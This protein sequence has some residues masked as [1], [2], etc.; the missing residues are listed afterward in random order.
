[1]IDSAQK[2]TRLSQ[3]FCACF[4]PVATV[5]TVISKSDEHNLHLR[6]R[7]IETALMKGLGPVIARFPMQELAIR[8]HYASDPDFREACEDYAIANCSLE[9]WQA[10]E[11]KSAHFKA[12]I[13]EL[14][15]EITA[16]LE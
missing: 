16:C 11:A 15:R 1:L 7:N 10:D 3:L 4:V 6:A 14:E 8:R 2:R 9:R 5:A 12:M 13:E